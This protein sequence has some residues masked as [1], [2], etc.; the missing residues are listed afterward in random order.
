MRRDFNAEEAKKNVSDFGQENI[1]GILK[2]IEDESKKGN[3]SCSF[4]FSLTPEIE[5]IIKSKGFIVSRRGKNSFI[6]KWGDT[7]NSRVM[8]FNW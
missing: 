2:K 8:I 3:V 1:E 4:D 6:V 5:D 7:K